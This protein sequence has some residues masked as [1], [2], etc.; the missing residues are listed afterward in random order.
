MTREESIGV[1]QALCA[2]LCFSTGAILVRWASALSPWEVTSLRMLLGALVV[3]GAAWVTGSRLRLSVAELRR[4]LPVGLVAAVHFVTFIGSLYFTTVAHSLT[5]VYTAPL[6]IAALSRSVLGEPLPKRTVPATLLAL[7]GVAVLTG[8]EPRLTRRMV[9]GDLLA[10]AAAA[11]F[12]LYSLLGRRERDRL[13]LLAYAS[14]VYFTAGIVTAPFAV[15]LLGRYAPPAALAAVVAMAVIPMALGHTLYNASVRRLHPSLPN[16]IAMQEVTL[17]IFLA[18]ALLGEV[19]PASA[20]VGAAI[21]L[22]GVCLVL[23][24]PRPRRGRA[25]A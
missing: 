13:P 1:A 9:T 17:A 18:W 4:L 22:A 10:V 16:L 24:E 11:T 5:L 21:T 15:G 2:T 25:A 20:L 19:P 6:F 12:A 23:R 3:S 7:L 8:L 14:W